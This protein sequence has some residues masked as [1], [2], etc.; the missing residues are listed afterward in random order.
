[1][2]RSGLHQKNNLVLDCEVTSKNIRYPNE[3]SDLNAKRKHI[4]KNV[5]L[6]NRIIYI[7]S[8]FTGSSLIEIGFLS[9]LP[10]KKLPNSEKVLIC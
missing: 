5:Y 4:V 1:M 3:I 10:C 2:W 8:H 6:I 7:L 9:F